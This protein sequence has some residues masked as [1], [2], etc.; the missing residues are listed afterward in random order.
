MAATYRDMRAK[1][2]AGPHYCGKWRLRE[3]H[4]VEINIETVVDFAEMV[5]PKRIESLEICIF[6]TET[7]FAAGSISRACHLLGCEI[8]NH[9]NVL[10][11]RTT[12]KEGLVGQNET[13]RRTLTVRERLSQNME[14][15]YSVRPIRYPASGLWGVCFDKL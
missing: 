3:A 5:L 1:V 11:S 10:A 6:S 8:S 14:T 15:R 13:C 4:S 7:A 2:V 9:R 12:T